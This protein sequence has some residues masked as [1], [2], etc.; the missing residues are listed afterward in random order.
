LTL[1]EALAAGLPAVCLDHHG[2]R[3]VMRPELGAIVGAGE[4]WSAI[5]R[6]L[7]DDA[8]RK[9]MGEAA[10]RYAEGERFE[11]RAAE[12]ARVIVR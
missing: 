12:L 10:R 5:A 2:A 4:L 8:G 11:A 7:E 6:L 1:L 9:R 3:S